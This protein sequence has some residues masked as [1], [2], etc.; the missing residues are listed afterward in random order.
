MTEKKT[1]LTDYQREQLAQKAFEVLLPRA[2]FRSIDEALW[3]IRA[4]R[5]EYYAAEITAYRR[6]EVSAPTPSA[7]GESH[8]PGCMPDGIAGAD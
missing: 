3:L 5:S 4:L 1:G 2:A 7:Q 6:P 8:P